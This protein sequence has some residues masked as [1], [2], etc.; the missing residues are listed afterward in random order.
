M[1]RKQIANFVLNTIVGYDR[2]IVAPVLEDWCEG[3]A[4]RKE[5]RHRLLILSDHLAPIIHE[6]GVPEL[7]EAV[8]GAL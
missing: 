3:R 7:A 4:F 8:R 6:H 5:D 2:I 1:D